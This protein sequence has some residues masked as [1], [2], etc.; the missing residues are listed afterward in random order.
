MPCRS[1]MFIIKVI[2]IIVIIITPPIGPDVIDF[3]SLNFRINELH[4]FSIFLLLSKLVLA[5]DEHLSE[6]IM[7]RFVE[8][9][10]LAYD[11]NL[12]LFTYE[13]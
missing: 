1:I 9:L 8:E 6:L 2:T 5:I 7:S 4:F 10:W 13:R 12:T 11:R 3:T